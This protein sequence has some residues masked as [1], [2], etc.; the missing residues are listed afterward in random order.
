MLK[1][2]RLVLRDF[3]PDD[4]R[5]VLAYQSDPRYLRY[6]PWTVRTEADVLAFV[7]RQVELQSAT[8]RLKF[9]LVI[10]LVG[11]GLVG[12]CGIRLAEP[13]SVEADVGYE[14]DPRHWGRGYATEAAGA[15]VAF[16][17]EALGV[18]RVWGECVADNV[19]SRRVMEKLGMIQEGRLREKRWMKGRWW[20]TLLY[21][22][23]R[24]EWEERWEEKRWIASVG[25]S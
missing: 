15:M 20:D 10:T 23:L 16:G 17:F 13:N 12:N 14:L 8:P 2:R 5:A 18:H 1:T 9:Q 21:G 11:V 25:A 3:R 4:W 19:A 24:K 6:Y 22:I 7:G